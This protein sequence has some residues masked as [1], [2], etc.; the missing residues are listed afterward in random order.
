MG[1]NNLKIQQFKQKIV[2]STVII[3]SH[4]VFL[5]QRANV[6]L[7]LCYSAVTIVLN[8]KLYNNWK[9]FSEKPIVFIL[10]FY[11]YIV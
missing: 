4:E 8:S 2:E 5:N 9:K 1:A 10:D 3:L 7:L 6:K 11:I